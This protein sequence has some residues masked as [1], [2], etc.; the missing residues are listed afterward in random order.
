MRFQ[1]ILDTGARGMGGQ[2]ILWPTRMTAQ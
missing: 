1:F 2:T